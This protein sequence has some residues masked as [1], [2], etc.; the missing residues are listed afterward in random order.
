MKNLF[1]VATVFIT[2]STCSLAQTGGLENLLANSYGVVVWNSSHLDLNR[3]ASQQLIM[4]R[5]S[6]GLQYQFTFGPKISDNSTVVT[7]DTISV[8]SIPGAIKN[9]LSQSKLQSDSVHITHY[10]LIERRSKTT[11]G[12]T[13]KYRVSISSG[14]QHYYNF[15]LGDD[16]F[17]EASSIGAPFVAAHIRLG[18]EESP[19]IIGVGLSFPA[20]DETA[21]A[22]R[23]PSR[24]LA[25]TLSVSSSR[26][27]AP[28]VSIGRYAE[29]CGM[30][31]WTD[32]GFQ[33]LRLS[34]LSYKANEAVTIKDFVLS[35]PN[36]RK[37][38]SLYAKFGV[39]LAFH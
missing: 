25:T 14:Y 20:M 33:H 7:I 12:V 31:F 15:T 11:I 21:I 32:I 24:N 23:D 4:N 28:E 22:F 36:E 35:L 17:I 29:W 10:T 26:A 1:H 6:I 38:I 27:F 2:I 5:S 3:A 13:G 34:G 16:R 18:D 37:I 39:S 30:K 8:D 9:N 19:W